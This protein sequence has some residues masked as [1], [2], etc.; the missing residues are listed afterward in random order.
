LKRSFLDRLAPLVVE[1]V[2]AVVIARVRLDPLRAAQRG[3]LEGHRHLAGLRRGRRGR[4]QGAAQHH[5]H[6]DSSHH[7]H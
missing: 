3:H 1:I 7:G 2:G 4:G 6:K 5:R